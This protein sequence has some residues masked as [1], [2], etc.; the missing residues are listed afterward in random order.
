MPVGLSDHSKDNRVAIAAI[1][2]GA[3][4]IEKHIALEK[5]KHGLD[6][7]FSLKGREI[8]KFKD[9]MIAAHKLLGKK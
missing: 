2:V 1:S 4:I 3:E 9:D 5:Q 8:K 6:I 7:A